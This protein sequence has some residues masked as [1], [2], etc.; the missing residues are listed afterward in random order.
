M[1]AV[2]SAVRMAAGA[3]LALGLGCPL[4]RA[5]ST[6]EAPV[7]ETASEIEEDALVATLA[8]PW[9]GDLAGIIEKLDYIKSL[10]A[11]TLYMTPVFRAASN[12]KYD[13]ADYKQVDPAFGTNADFERLCSEAAKRGIRVIPD[14]SLNHVGADSP[15]FNRYGNHP[16]GG[17]FDNGKINPASPPGTV[18][19]ATGPTSATPGATRSAGSPQGSVQPA[20]SVR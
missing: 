2:R 13:T 6:G 10:G 4:A 14:T 20:S 19:A 16:A 18:G 12:H 15:Y 7:A 9:T 17:A 11:N 8:A 1:V 5:G 3:L